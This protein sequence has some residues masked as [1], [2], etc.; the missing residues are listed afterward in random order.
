M[1]NQHPRRASIR[2][3]GNREFDEGITLG[4]HISAGSQA[5]QINDRHVGVGVNADLTGDRE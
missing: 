5:L 3:A 4:S 1:F 2:E